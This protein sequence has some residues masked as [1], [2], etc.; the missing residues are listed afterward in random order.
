MFS[1]TIARSLIATFGKGTYFLFAFWLLVGAPLVI[2]IA[3]LVGAFW[4]RRGNWFGLKIGFS[5][6]LWA[7][8]CE[9]CIPYLGMYPN[10][11]GAILGLLA[12]AGAGGEATWIGQAC[13]HGFNMTV[14]PVST[15][16]LFRFVRPHAGQETASS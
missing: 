14:W 2:L 8:L 12:G 10:I 1:E 16:L 7:S 11:P 6:A 5:V 15:W 4:R 9:I 13:I 3:A